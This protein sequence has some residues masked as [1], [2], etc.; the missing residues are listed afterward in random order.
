MTSRVLGIVPQVSKLVG[1]GTASD[2][3]CAESCPPGLRLVG[4]A[5]PVTS[6]VLGVALPPVPQVAL[7][8]A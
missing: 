2:L 8:L 6:R 3:S 1:A 5:L 4:A 7:F